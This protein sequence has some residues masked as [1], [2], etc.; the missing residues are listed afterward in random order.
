MKSGQDPLPQSIK[1]YKPLIGRIRKDN[2]P[3]F[4]IDSSWRFIKAKTN[5]NATTQ[6]TRI[7]RTREDGEDGNFRF[8]RSKQITTNS[9]ISWDGGEGDDG[10]YP[11]FTISE[12]GETIF[13]GWNS[14][15]EYHDF[16][17]FTDEVT[18]NKP[19]TNNVPRPCIDGNIF[20]TEGD[21][22]KFNTYCEPAF[23]HPELVIPGYPNNDI[24]I[25]TIMRSEGLFLAD[26]A[27]KFNYYLEQLGKPKILF[28][29]FPEFGSNE[30]NDVYFPDTILDTDKK[31]PLFD[32]PYLS[33]ESKN[34]FFPNTNLIEFREQRML[35]ASE[36]NELQEKFY[37][38]QSSLIKYYNKWLSKNNLKPEIKNILGF[39]EKF[40]LNWISTSLNANT[41]VKCN[42]AIP[43]E[44]TALTVGSRNENE[45]AQIKL[46]PCEIMLYTS[47]NFSTNSNEVGTLDPS[48]AHN[49]MDF[50]N[51]N[52]QITG[53]LDLSKVTETN[54]HC[55]TL[56]VDTNNIVSC[57]EYNELRDNS[58]QDNNSS[59]PCGA[60]RNY[61][62]PTNTLPIVQQDIDINDIVFDQIVIGR[63][64]QLTLDDL[65]P[66]NYISTEN[67]YTKY[68]LGYMKRENGQINFYYANG[69]KIENI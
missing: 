39:S 66:F 19:L 67:T 32:S 56:K 14:S 59:A 20:Y 41:F 10:P 57:N 64:Q 26:K 45:I 48:L 3:I 37:K 5:P 27:E 63:S 34:S 35:Q 11:N 16:L 52:S 58:S 4:G 15:L 23:F 50:I 9:A 43:I 38:K 12:T 62:Y 29:R 69:V 54:I 18:Y 25:Y 49:N 31:Y 47:T 40:D 53:E 65:T 44:T 21:Q 28:Y 1:R 42:T 61:I 55:I 46:N 30:T 60:N 33:R 6:D 22:L 17:S 68:L 7:Y 51:I 8:A 36:L 13:V 2:W 24:K